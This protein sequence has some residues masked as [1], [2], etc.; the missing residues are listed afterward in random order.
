MSN[1]YSK[2]KF[3]KV[4]KA[5]LTKFSLYST[6]PVITLA[7][8][9]GVFCLAGANGLGKST[10]LSAINYGLT[11]IV[12]DPRK[13]ES[14]DEYY[15]YGLRFTADFFTG[16]INE[17][18]RDAAEITLDI[19]V[20]HHFYQITRGMFELEELRGLKKYDTSTEPH[21]L[22]SDDSEMSPKER[23]E[24][25]AKSIAS[26]VGV[27]SFEQFVF[28]QHFV[29]TFDER[30]L[31]L[32]F[33]K[34]V[35]EQVL[36]L[37]F[38]VDAV[39]AKRADALRRESEK[40]DSLV[41]NYNWQATEI[42]KKI[43]DIEATSAPNA[44]V[45]AASEDL[46]A[47]HEKLLKESDLDHADVD[48]LD[49]E[50]K[51]AT[52]RLAE[53]SAQQVVLRNEYAEEFS[54]RIQQHS[55]VTHHPLIV[56]SIAESVCGLC[57]AMGQ[58]VRKTIDARANGDECPLCQSLLNKDSSKPK[59]VKRLQEID[60]QLSKSKHE[61]D[62]AV[63]A[64]DRLRPEL[65]R[66]RKRLNDIKGRLDD[67]ERS[68]ERALLYLQTA[69]KESSE[70]AV[71]LETYRKQM[72]EFLRKKEENK[73][74]RDEKRKALR[75]LQQK[76]EKQY[77]VAEEDFVPLFKDLANRFL[78]LDLDIKMETSITPSVG[79]ALEIKSK[80]R[81]QE[82][83]LSE[84]QRFFVDIALRMAL[85][86]FMSDADAKASLFIDTPEG[87]LDIA[88]ENR[89]GDMLARFVGEGHHVIMTA[90]IN[91]S[92]LIQSLAERCGRLKMTLC[93]MT[94][95]AE[96][97]DVQIEEEDLFEQAFSIIEQALDSP[98]VSIHG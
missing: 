79:L 57:G 20:G 16:R 92:R 85:A 89:A 55:H 3:P 41:R 73:I 59:D 61:L 43:K 51:D 34:K 86:H 90:N 19:H 8:P 95:W 97:S 33:D 48:R 62:E 29:M 39:G 36:Y 14:V 5:V 15:R 98:K 87:S 50:L 31:L 80:V 76:L 6:K 64:I 21:T 70:L 69:S 42:R 32:F 63:K 77:A 82:Y 7:I 88:Y 93:R 27:E 1:A 60:Q 96:L 72:E 53:V 35:L 22:V 26:D 13:F 84:S 66:A 46:G 58:R 74:K 67:F 37:A 91:S 68:N 12:S 2:L 71:L 44:K 81:R 23:Q 38:G 52:L 25:Y 11:G 40:A 28:L 45:E 17:T 49:S 4:T 78:G 94:E 18:D 30:R 56:S 65:E 24:E 75:K 10:F 47:E 9:D 83:Q 54:R